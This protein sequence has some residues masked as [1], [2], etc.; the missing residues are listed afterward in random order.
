MPRLLDRN[1]Y[2]IVYSKR[3][4][5]G[6]SY[7]VSSAGP[8][9]PP[10][11]IEQDPDYVVHLFNQVEPGVITLSGGEPLIWSELPGIIDRL[12][13]HHWVILTNLYRCPHWLLWHPNIKMVVAAYHSEHAN[14]RD[15]KAF[16]AGLTTRNRCVVKVMYNES[17]FDIWKELDEYGIPT[18]LV[19][20]EGNPP[21]DSGFLDRFN[22][23]ELLT[24]NMYNARFFY[25]QWAHRHHLC[26][27]GTR[28]M[29]QLGINKR[30]RRC[31]QTGHTI[32]P[33]RFNID[34]GPCDQSCY[35]EWHHWAGATA[36]NDND[37]WNRYIETGEWTRP[38]PQE[39][40]EF[41]DRMGWA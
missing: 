8:A 23:G 18:H 24:S 5:Y 34:S 28:D 20:F 38:T 16:A 25:H 15:F 35:C 4:N 22:S 14:K 11:K 13:Q 17:T 32:D 26:V 30:L 29:F 41:R 27:A 39:F 1:Q 31:S 40:K 37:T 7:C 21:E 33:D 6:C 19:P 3:C 2:C 12:P 36:A 10:S 9:L